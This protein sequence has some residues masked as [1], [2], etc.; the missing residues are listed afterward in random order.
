MRDGRLAAIDTYYDVA[1][2]VRQS[3][4]TPGVGLR[5]YGLLRLN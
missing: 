4:Q 2:L 3:G 5:P 1:T